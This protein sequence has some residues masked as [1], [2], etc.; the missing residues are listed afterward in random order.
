M[1]GELCRHVGVQE[2][3]WR[4]LDSL[5]VAGLEQTAVWRIRY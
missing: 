3:W 4:K 5:L 1:I 2:D